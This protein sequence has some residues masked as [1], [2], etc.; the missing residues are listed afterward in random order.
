MK[1]FKDGEGA[2]AKCGPL[3]AH[4]RLRGKAFEWWVG[5]AIVMPNGKTKTMEEGKV[6]ATK[7][8][9]EIVA[10]MVKEL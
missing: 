5:G 1:W 2:V 7:A 3:S 8:M 9:S 6:K 10:G 4:V